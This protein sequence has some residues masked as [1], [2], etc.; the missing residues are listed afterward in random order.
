M[1]LGL[2]RPGGAVARGV[3]PEG[4]VGASLGLALGVA[5]GV[6]AGFVAGVVADADPSCFDFGSSGAWHP[7]IASSI[8]AP[9]SRDRER[10]GRRG[11]G[12]LLGLDPGIVPR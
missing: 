9:S 5:P 12:G 4:L 2:L 7:V 11:I 6:V 8:A 1:R 3:S 10:G